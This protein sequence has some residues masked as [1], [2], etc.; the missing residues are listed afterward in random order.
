MAGGLDI[1]V[2]GLGPIM[3]RLAKVATASKTAL[4][5]GVRNGT[6]LL[7]RHV[8]KTIYSGHDQRHLEGDT[9]R[10]RGGIAYRIEGE[11]LEAELGTNVEYGPIHEFGGEI[12]PLGHPFLA[13]PI[14]DMKGSPREHEDLFFLPTGNEGVLLDRSGRLQY[15]LKRRVE[16]PARPYFGPAVDERGQDVA[17]ELVRPLY[18]LVDE[19]LPGAQV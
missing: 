12:V 1:A 13:I 14:G 19:P 8:L 5:K 16:I 15:S 18:A 6:L 17:A 2:V 9:N 10:L 3:D 11:G 7:H 4:A